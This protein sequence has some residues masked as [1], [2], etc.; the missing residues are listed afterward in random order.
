MSDDRQESV[1]VEVSLNMRPNRSNKLRESRV[2]R[3]RGLKQTLRDLAATARAFKH[4]QQG[5][6]ID[7]KGETSR[8]EKDNVR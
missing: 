1:H 3:E 6:S 2:N 8:K 4:L 5:L 7:E